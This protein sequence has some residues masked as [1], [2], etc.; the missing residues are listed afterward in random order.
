MRAVVMRG[1]ILTGMMVVV[2]VF[3]RRH[4]C[5]AHDECETST[6][7]RQHEARWNECPKEQQPE[8]E[9]RCPSWIPNVP[10]PFHCCADLRTISANRSRRWRHFAILRRT[11]HIRVIS[12]PVRAP[13]SARPVTGEDF[14]ALNYP[15]WPGSRL[16]DPRWPVTSGSSGAVNIRRRRYTWPCHAI[17]RSL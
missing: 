7:W 12:W 9:Q 1:V 4:L 2:L 11:A 10:H 14:S 13:E 16:S 15:F 17:R 3:T 5:I 8:D 6:H